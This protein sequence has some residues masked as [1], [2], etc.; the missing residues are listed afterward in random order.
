MYFCRK[1][2]CMCQ[3]LFCIVRLFKYGN[4]ILKFQLFAKIF[5]II[6]LLLGYWRVQKICILRR[7]SFCWSHMVHIE[8]VGMNEITKQT[9]IR[10]YFITDYRDTIFTRNSL[11]LSY[12]F[13]FFI[14]AQRYKGL[15]S[16]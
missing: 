3:K 9:I 7:N 12:Y 4:G 15:F 10:I 1:Y 14:F 6:Y 11:K 5:A 2:V 8:I 16:S 13:T